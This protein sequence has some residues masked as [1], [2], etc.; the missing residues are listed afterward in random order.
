MYKTKLFINLKTTVGSFQSERMWPDLADFLEEL[1]RSFF[2]NDFFTN[3][4]QKNAVG[5][6]LAQNMNTLK[7]HCVT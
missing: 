1:H 7:R 5:Y 2:A 4:K 3:F 6:R